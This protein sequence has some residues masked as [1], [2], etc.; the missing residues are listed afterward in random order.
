VDPGGAATYAL[1]IHP[2]D[3]PHS[4]TLVTASPSP[5]LTLALD[6]AVVAPSGVAT[7]TATDSHGGPGLLPGLWHTIPITGSGGGFAHTA[8]V[9]LLVGGARAYLPTVMREP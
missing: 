3:L 5:S 9:D 2:S 1:R 4:V 7:L 6:P 8:E